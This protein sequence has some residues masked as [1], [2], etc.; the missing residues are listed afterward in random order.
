MKGKENKQ[1]SNRPT[2]LK[3]VQLKS[4]MISDSAG[5][6]ARSWSGLP[7]GRKS[8]CVPAQRAFLS[9]FSFFSPSSLSLFSSTVNALVLGQVHE[10]SQKKD[11]H[12]S[13]YFWM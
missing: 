4:H 5:H 9:L 6:I 3:G 11:Y 2:L 13:P 10:E 7:A 12:L 1:S 8:Q